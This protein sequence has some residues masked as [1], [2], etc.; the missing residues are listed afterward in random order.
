MIRFS[1]RI[2]A[3]LHEQGTAQAA[4]DRRSLNSEILHLL[5][6]ALIAPGRGITRRRSGFSCPA[7]G[8]TGFLPGLKAGTSSGNPGERTTRTAG[9]G[10]RVVRLCGRSGGAGVVVVRLRWLPEGR[11]ALPASGGL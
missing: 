11:T 1:L 6:V 5:E 8:E 10:V 2:P 9:V 7:P 3:D 4:A